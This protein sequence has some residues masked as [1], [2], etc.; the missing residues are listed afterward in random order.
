MKRK[1]I[2]TL[3]STFV[4]ASL[5]FLPASSVAT[6]SEWETKKETICETLEVANCAETVDYNPAPIVIE[7]IQYSVK[8][9]LE[10]HAIS[11]TLAGVKNRYQTKDWWPYHNMYLNWGSS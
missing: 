4:A 2:T 6:A 7:G 10:H 1:H 8:D 3:L 9:G 5:T 11:G